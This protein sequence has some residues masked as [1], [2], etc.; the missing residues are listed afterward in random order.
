MKQLIRHIILLF[1]IF[2]SSY[3]FGCEEN[4][5]QRFTVVDLH[6]CSVASPY[7]IAIWILVA[8]LAKLRK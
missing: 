1:Y 2:S 3:V 7:T 8:S 5:L 6:W 4:K